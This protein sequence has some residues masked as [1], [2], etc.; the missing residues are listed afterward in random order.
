MV[1]HPDI[2]FEI[3]RQRHREFVAA[4]EQQRITKAFGVPRPRRRHR[5]SR[6]ERVPRD[7]RSSPKVPAGQSRKPGWRRKRRRRSRRRS[8]L[9]RALAL[10]LFSATIY[11]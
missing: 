2:H 7:P 5:A 6:V 8:V 9:T 4:A 10:P 3:A 11:R 1:L